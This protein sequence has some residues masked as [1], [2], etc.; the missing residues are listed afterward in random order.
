VEHSEERGGPQAGQSSVAHVGTTTLALPDPPEAAATH[1]RTRR[2]RLVVLGLTTSCLVL[3]VVSARMYTTQ[4]SPHVLPSR[5]FVPTET[6]PVSDPELS[7]FTYSVLGTG[8]TR[9]E[10]A[11]EGFSLELPSGWQTFTTDQLG[12]S[13]RFSASSILPPATYGGNPQVYVMRESTQGSPDPERSFRVWRHY[14]SSTAGQNLVGTVQ[15]RRT[16]LRD[17]EAFILTFVYKT[18]LGVRGEMMFGLI[19]GG[20][21][22]RL[23]FVLPSRHLG[24]FEDLF[25]DIAM[26]F[27]I[28]A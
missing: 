14:L 8:W 27:E 2:R 19:R 5:Q 17:G 6:P 22:Y 28:A 7:S 10:S 13:L 15:M 26:R 4:P 12:P 25:H 20:S 24:D 18:E 21:T 1:T 16:Q 11:S 9:Y 23:V 3:I